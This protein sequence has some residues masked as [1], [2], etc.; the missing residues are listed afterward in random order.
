MN[1]EE[2]VQHAMMGVQKGP[3]LRVKRVMMIMVLKEGEIIA[4][5]AKR[6]NFKAIQMCSDMVGSLV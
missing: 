2:E 5:G 6:F 3:T 1:R 4:V